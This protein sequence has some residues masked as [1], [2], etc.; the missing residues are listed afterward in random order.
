V[1]LWLLTHLQQPVCR[2]KVLEHSGI[3]PWKNHSELMTTT[4]LEV[5]KMI[6]VERL[7]VG[8][9][10]MHL[11]SAGLKREQ[12]TG[13]RGAIETAEVSSR[14]E[15][16]PASP[17]SSPC[18]SPRTPT[19][20]SSPPRSSSKRAYTSTDPAPSAPVKAPRPANHMNIHTLS[21]RRLV[22]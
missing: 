11:S 2:L 5:S 20:C 15:D 8:L 16:T 9:I 10:E 12:R 14:F 3:Q 17:F 4:C 7:S 6:A 22:L 18:C 21:P 1:N 19:C 13:R